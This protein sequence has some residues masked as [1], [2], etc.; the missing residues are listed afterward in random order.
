MDIANR[1]EE[2]VTIENSEDRYNEVLDV[3]VK[4]Q[5]SIESSLRRLL[6]F[7]ENWSTQQT[8]INRIENWM[9]TAEK[10]LVPLSDTSNGSMRRF[11]V[12][13]HSFLSDFRKKDIYSVQYHF[14]IFFIGIKSSI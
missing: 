3:I 12:S 8:L 5:D 6:S 2:L 10:E 11:W 9:T 4:L 14:L 7:R 1:L 13:F